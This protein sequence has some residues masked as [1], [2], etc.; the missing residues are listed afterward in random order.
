MNLID[1]VRRILFTP[2]SEWRVIERESGDPVQLFVKYAAIL[3]LIPAIAGF[4]GMS[5]VGVKVSIGTFRV[6]LGAGLVNAVIS[7]LFTFVLVYIVALTVDLLAPYF[8]GQR[9]FTSA[10]KLSVYSFTPAWLAGIFLLIPGLRFLTILGLYGVYLMGT[11]LPVLM[12]AARESAMAYT[13]LVAVVALITAFA[14]A[15]I[16]SVVLP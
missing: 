11:G 13:A 1:R 3:A 16:Q 6:P 14:L 12:G 15:A 2:S 9:N 5:M 7:Y 8:H 10:L 4:I